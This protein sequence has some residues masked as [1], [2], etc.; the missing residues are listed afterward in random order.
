MSW[1]GRFTADRV[2]TQAEADRIHA[3]AATRGF[4]VWIEAKIVPSPPEPP[5]EPCLHVQEPEAGS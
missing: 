4:T 5:P 1:L 3:I 2:M